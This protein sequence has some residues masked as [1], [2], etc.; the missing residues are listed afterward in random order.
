MKNELQRHKTSD[1]I[2]WIFTVIG[3]VLVFALIAGICL[4]LF[5]TDD[6]YKPSE[7]FK[8][9]EK[10]A[11]E[12]D[13][14]E[15]TA[16][17]HRHK[18]MSASVSNDEDENAGI[19][20]HSSN[21]CPNCGSVTEAGVF[22]EGNCS[23]NSYYYYR[24]TNEDCGSGLSV[25]VPN[26]KNP[27]KHTGFS[28]TRDITAA[29]CVAEGSALYTCR[30]CGA[31]ETRSVPA[32][33]VHNYSWVITT[34]PVGDGSGVESYIC[35]GCSNVTQTRTIFALPA[36]PEK[37][38]YHFVGWYTDEALTNAYNS[39]YIYSDTNLYAKFEINRCTVTFNSDGGTE[40]DSVTVD[41]NTVITP[42]VPEKTGYNF[43]GWAKSD[44][45][46][47]EGEAIKG[48]MTLLALW[49]IKTFTVTFYVNDTL[50]TTVT[51]EYGSVLSKVADDVAVYANNIIS[52]ANVNG[53]TPAV[54]A[55]EMLVE[56]DIV[57]MA[58]EP[59]T[60]EKIANTIKNNKWQ[61][62][63]G[64]AGGLVLIVIIVAV[65]GS[66]KRKV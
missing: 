8:S 23:R 58:R 3:F 13:D 2:K 36:D 4:Q 45:T 39:D 24:C 65:C 11:P 60:E 29:T 53:E 32:T 51:V 35:N 42:F 49:Q 25:E 30:G 44:G 43:I 20:L 40:L 12:T 55:N 56:G 64:V 19:E 61:I 46:K 1:K 66:K 57:V 14:G 15:T 21:L 17:L 34:K 41:W 63:G 59:S 26:S 9:T 5:A 18:V 28:Y 47:Y 54:P 50:Y 37:E 10:A 38:G 33:G 27:N 6:K 31:T 16:V 48:D 52:F 7:W 62:I 22:N